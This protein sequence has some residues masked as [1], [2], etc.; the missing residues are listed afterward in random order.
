MNIFTILQMAAE[1]HPDRTAL[2]HEDAFYSYA[3]LY[4]AA[5]NAALLFT[6]QECQYVSVLDVS[7]VAVPIALFGAAAA[8]LSYVPLNYR[9]AESDINALKQRIAPCYL[10]GPEDREA[11]LQRTLNTVA[12]SESPEPVYDGELAAVQLFTSGTTGTPK[13]AIL[14]HRNLMSYILSTVEFSSAN[15]DDRAL[16]SVPPYHIAGISALLSNFYSARTLVLLSDF[17]PQAWCE[18]IEKHRVS[19]AFVVPTMLSRIIDYLATCDRNIDFS[20]LR[21]LAYGG[22]KMPLKTIEAAMQRMP[23]VAFTNAYG[24]T[25]TSSTITLLGPE[26]H[27]QAFASTDVSGRARLASVGKPVP[28]ITVDIRNE[29]GASVSSG[30]SGMVFV[31]GEQVSGEYLEKSAITDGWFPTQDMGRIDSEGYLF[32]EGRLDDV[33]V[34]GGENISPGEIEDV[35]MKHD[36]VADACAIGV[37]DDEWGEA[38]ALLVVADRS[39]VEEEVLRGLIKQQLRSSRLPSHIQYV[40][41]LPYNENGK[42]LRRVIREKILELGTE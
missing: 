20:S 25:E 4:R 8:G 3:E 26:E 37:P 2:I 33:I 16:V 34:R 19:S 12:N 40:D 24:L 17:T 32:L 38:I 39:A 15:E 35:V 27:R 9:L 18:H 36:A 28:G 5:Q 14:R 31:R 6:E 10:I 41:A 42:L 11:F 21:A 22:G 23:G 7:S 1:C 30:E 13:A 29:Q